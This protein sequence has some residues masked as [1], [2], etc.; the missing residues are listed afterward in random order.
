MPFKSA[1]SQSS[2]QGFVTR[3]DRVVNMSSCSF[4]EGRFPQP[5]RYSWHRGILLFSYFSAGLGCHGDKVSYLA[6]FHLCK[7]GRRGTRTGVWLQVTFLK[8]PGCSSPGPAKPLFTS[9][10]VLLSHVHRHMSHLLC[11]LSFKK[12]TAPLERFLFPLNREDF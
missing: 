6:G 9:W 2:T 3:N 4:H 7:H 8:V 10:H 1:F 12:D 5:R 11:D